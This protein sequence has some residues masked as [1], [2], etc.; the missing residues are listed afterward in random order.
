M[1][2]KVCKSVMVTLVCSMWYTSL[3]N[4]ICIGSSFSIPVSIMVYL[5]GS[6]QI[7]ILIEELYCFNR[8]LV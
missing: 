3:L 1:C 8:S 4:I 6:K 5:K 2:S 7:N